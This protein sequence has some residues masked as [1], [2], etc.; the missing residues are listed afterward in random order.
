M[1]ELPTTPEE[2]A[3]Q[4]T[5][6][7]QVFVAHGD[8][9]TATTI[10]VIEQAAADYAPDHVTIDRTEAGVLYY[11][12]LHEIDVWHGDTG[13]AAEG[14]LADLHEEVSKCLVAAGVH[15]EAEPA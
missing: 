7:F 5:A 6:R 12:D 14:V 3:Y 15:A 13:D 4:T 11:C 1:N 10:E 9:D 8:H 2:P